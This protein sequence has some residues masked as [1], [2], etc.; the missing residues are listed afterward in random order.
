MKAVYESG[1]SRWISN[2][3]DS[4]FKNFVS[5]QV[6]CTTCALGVATG[7]AARDMARLVLNRGR[8]GGGG[9]PGPPVLVQ[10]RKWPGGPVR[11]GGGGGRLLAVG[12]AV[13]AG[14]GLSGCRCRRR[15]TNGSPQNVC[16]GMR[17]CCA[18]CDE[19]NGRD[20]RNA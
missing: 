9:A 2:F 15:D 4:L 19:G 1:I 3:M 18:A 20:T 5:M 10:P 13:V 11:L 8:Q 7:A 17:L 12:N 6:P 16:M 14:V